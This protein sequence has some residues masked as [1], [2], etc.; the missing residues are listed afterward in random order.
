V[1]SHHAHFASNRRRSRLSTRVT[2]RCWR[3]SCGVLRRRRRRAPCRWRF[4]S[5]RTTCPGRDGSGAGASTRRRE[6]STATLGRRRARACTDDSTRATSVSAASTNG[7]SVRRWTT[8]LRPSAA[9]RFCAARCT[10]AACTTTGR[11]RP[12]VRPRF[13]TSAVATSTSVG[14]RRRSHGTSGSREPHATCN[15]I[16]ALKT[17]R[18]ACHAAYHRVTVPYRGCV[19]SLYQQHSAIAS[20]GNSTVP[21]GIPHLTCAAPNTRTLVAAR[22]RSIH[23]TYRGQRGHHARVDSAYCATETGKERCRGRRSCSSALRPGR[24]ARRD[25]SFL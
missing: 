19:R 6:R 11:D 13:R 24:A 4:V 2:C 21:I 23:R 3:R 17:R 10:P 15:E 9:G 8:D 25:A 14:R 18:V 16:V 1:R 20:S 22:V 12:T 7:S 5:L